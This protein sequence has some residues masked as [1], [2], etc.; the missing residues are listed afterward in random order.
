MAFLTPTRNYHYRVMPFVLK[1]V[2]STYQMMVMRM[3]VAQLVKN[4]E[5]YIDDMVVKRK[6]ISKHL[7]DLD[8]VFSILRRY[9]LPLN[10][11][12]CS[13]SV[14]LGKFMGYIFTHQ[15]FKVN[16]DQIK[17]IHNLHPPWNPKEVQRLTGMTVA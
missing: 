13:S 5:A 16:L 3:F 1:N 10:A 12:K 7:G 17:T 6:E 15:G 2:R 9:R 14:G 11:S 8:E 4:F